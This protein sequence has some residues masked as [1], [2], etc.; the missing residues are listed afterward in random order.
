MQMLRWAEARSC[1]VRSGTQC[2][3]EKVHREVARLAVGIERMFC[4]VTGK[5]HYVWFAFTRRNTG[6]RVAS[7]SKSTSGERGVTAKY[8]GINGTIR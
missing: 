1:V 8:G 7:R 5:E 4:C 2:S 3:G 6:C